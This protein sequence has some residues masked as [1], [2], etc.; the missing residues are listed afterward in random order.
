MNFPLIGLHA[1]LGELGA[2]LFFWAFVELVGGQARNI[3]RAR[4]AV[5]LGT[6]FLIGAWFAGGFY[7]VEF[8]GNEVKPLIKEGPMP[9]AHGV[10][11]ETKEHVFLFLP[12]LGVF[13][14]GLMQRLGHVMDSDRQARAAAL[15]ATG[16]VVLLSGTMAL[17][18]FLVSSS[19]RAALEAM[20]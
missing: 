1:G 13:A 7:Y 2:L 9:W 14:W 6:L 16:A 11:M 12:F 3:R 4:L 15:Y 8:Y 20:L 19:Y 5:L 17:M 18:G 10:A